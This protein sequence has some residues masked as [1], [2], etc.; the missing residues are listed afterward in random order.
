VIPEPIVFV[1]GPARGGTTFVNNLLAEWFDYTMGPEGT[2]VG[3]L[4]Q[5]LRSYGDLGVDEN[6]ERLLADIAAAEM[7]EIMRSKWPVQHR[8]D[9]TPSLMRTHL[10]ERSYAG[11]VHAALSALRTAR[12]RVRLGLKSPDYWMELDTLESIFGRQARYLFV[13]RDGR[14]VALSNFQ[15]SWGQR[16]A[17][18]SAR[19]WVRMLEAVE[20]FSARVGPDRLLTLRY[21]D[22]LTAP[23]PSIVAI[24]RFLEA[25][26]APERRAQLLATMAAN[27]RR[28]NFGKWKQK[29]SADELRAFES[30]AARHLAAHGY[31]VV[32]PA[33]SV[34]VLEVARFSF[35]ETMRKVVATVR[36]D[37]LGRR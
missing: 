6:L 9:I 26:L 18:A 27:P 10:T 33:A 28:D 15:V 11:A 21:E 14:D 34:S 23:E 2:F 13:L 1:F 3:P 25:P 17:H 30:V 12:G 22:I 5:R 4:N 37:I 36:K 20:S 16:N 24:E 19:R 8:V 31:E 32:N 7:F 29:M 35:E